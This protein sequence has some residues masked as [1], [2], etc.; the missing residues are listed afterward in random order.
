LINGNFESGDNGAWTLGSNCTIVNDSLEAHTG[1]HSL[2]IVADGEWH[3]TR[4]N[5][6]V[7][8][9]HEYQIEGYI[10]GSNIV[11]ARPKIRCRFFDA[12]DNRLS[13]EYF[14]GSFGTTD[15][16]LKSMR[17]TAPEN[18]TRLE[19]HPY[20]FNY[21]TSGTVWFDDI[22]VNDPNWQLASYT[23]IVNSGSGSGDYTQGT[24]INI[25]ADPPPAGMVFDQWTGDVDTIAN[26]NEAATTIIMPTSDV[27]ISAIYKYHLLINGDFELGDSSDWTL[28]SNC[29]IVNDSSK[30][31]TCSYSLQ[32]VANGGW[33]A[34]KQDIREVTAGHEY[35]IEGYISGSNI[36]GARPKIRCRFFDADDN[37]LTTGYLNGAFGTTD[38][39][40]KSMR[41]TAPE[42]AARLEIHP[43]VFNYITSGT[44]WF[45]DITVI[46]LDE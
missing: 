25:S 22:T 21:I 24:A 2:R 34:T 8:A 27:T 3:A 14:N 29:S 20:V 6:D 4:Q 7:A 15:Y 31:H 41:I 19:I 26:V 5:V 32:I 37:R 33:H 10:S 36:I 17:I 11:G 30:A 43:Y 13:T 42:N 35:Q 28:G 40:L 1:S 38:Y 16:E 46:D 23:L 44:A 12:D 18:A 9:G 45:D 39:E